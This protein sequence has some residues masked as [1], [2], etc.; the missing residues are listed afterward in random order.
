[1]SRPRFPNRSDQDWVDQLSGVRG[2]QAQQAAHHDLASY[3]YVV[4]YNYL[5]K[6]RTSVMVLADFDNDELA[7]LARD[8]VQETLEKL[9]NNQHELLSQYAQTGRFTSWAAQIISNQIASELRRPYWKRR[10]PLSTETFARRADEEGP[11]PEAAALLG[12]TRAILQGCL[13]KLPERYRIAL[14]RCIAEGE[15]AEAVA[16]DLDTT[17]N[18]VYLLVYR[19]KRTMRTCVTKAGLDHDIFRIFS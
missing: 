1:M 10:E 17:A 18:A 6:R 7:E 15:R 9:A 11:Q 13:Q 8:F 5:D 4:A 3:L 12:E 14:V 2:P 16:N 19:A